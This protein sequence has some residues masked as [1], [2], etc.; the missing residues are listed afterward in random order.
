MKK[1]LAA[2]L[3][4]P[5]AGLARADDKTEPKEAPKPQAVKFELVPSG[6]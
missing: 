6:H 4:V 5:L 3:F 2:L 1:I